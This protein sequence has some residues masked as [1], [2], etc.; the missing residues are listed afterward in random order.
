LPAIQASFE[1]DDI[2]IPLNFLEILSLSSKISTLN[3]SPHKMNDDNA[4]KLIDAI[5]QERH[6]HSIVIDFKW[7]RESEWSTVASASRCSAA[8]SKS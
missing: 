5:R 6:C 8:V 7:F 1:Q 4:K 3:L 2:I